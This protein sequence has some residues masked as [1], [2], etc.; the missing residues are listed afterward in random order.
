MVQRHTSDQDDFTFGKSLKRILIVSSLTVIFIGIVATAVRYVTPQWNS[1]ETRGTE[2]GYT[3][4]SSKREL[5]LK[6]Y[7]DWSN[8]ETQKTA[9]RSDSQLVAAYIAQQIAV[10]ARMKS[11][12][13]LILPVE[14]PIE[15]ET[16]LKTH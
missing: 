16:F 6:L 11:E 10:V 13:A 7:Q 2:R 8:L 3:Y 12:A 9:S 15:V 14:V 5:L 4:V 1:I